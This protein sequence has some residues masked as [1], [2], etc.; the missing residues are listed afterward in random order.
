MHN[1]FELDNM[2]MKHIG[3]RSLGRIYLSELMVV[4]SYPPTM[5]EPGQQNVLDCQLLLIFTLWLYPKQIS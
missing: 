4:Y 3:L 2:G 1:G 5:V